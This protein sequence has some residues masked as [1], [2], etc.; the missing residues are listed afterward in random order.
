MFIDNVESGGCKIR[1]IGVGG[2]GSNAVNR[3]IALNIRYADYIAINTDMQ[4]L[5]LSRARHKIQIGAKLTKGKGA[6][7]DPNIGRQA[8]E[9]SKDA[10]EE[11]I[12]DAD[13]VFVTAGMG[14]GTGTGAAP[15]VAQ[16]AKE[17][18][19]LTVGVVTTPFSFEAG[20]RTEKAR[21]GLIALAKCVD[22]LMVIP[23]ERLL[24]VLPPQVTFI[25][26]LKYA[27]DVLRQ[28][29][30][31]IADL[32]ASP[33]II[34]LDFAD[35]STV[36]RNS[37]L[38]HIGIGDAKGENRHVEAVK[39]AVYSPLLDTTIDNATELI[40]NIK[41]GT[42][43][44]LHEANEIASLIK[45]VISPSANVIF[46]TSLDEGESD[47]V[48]VYV[49]ATGF[50][51]SKRQTQPAQQQYVPPMT[52]A[53]YV[54]QQQVPNQNPQFRN[55]EYNNQF[56]TQAPGPVLQGLK[57]TNLDDDDDTSGVPKA[58]RRIRNE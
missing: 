40:L 25:D 3:M 17:K 7:S 38:A 30:M 22:S 19:I 39:K 57:Q 58:L 28:G 4:A 51:G 20:Q 13:L 2:G 46:G 5:Q 11:A 56:R 27:D 26:A 12:R 35:I 21:S 1:V 29:I 16:I 54:P 42:D 6:G 14:G 48:S 41:G 53:R 32:I 24:R 37:G 18:G 50:D 47:K 52:S 45:S 10:I 23:N 44:G 49:I 34:N 15:I 9:E 43:L 33:G 31:G 55:V 36:L 8:A